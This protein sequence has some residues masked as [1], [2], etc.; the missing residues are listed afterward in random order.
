MPQESESR[1]LDKVIVRLPDGMRD[2]LKEAASANGRSMNAEIVARLENSFSIDAVEKDFFSKFTNIRFFMDVLPAGLAARIRAA[3]KARKRSPKEEV[4]Q[5]LEAAY[6]PPANQTLGEIIATLE[7]ITKSTDDENMQMLLHHFREVLRKNPGTENN[8]V[9]GFR[10]EGPLDVLPET[11]E[12]SE[13]G[14]R[15]ERSDL[16][17]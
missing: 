15:S 7:A 6:P 17:D 12:R 2:K 10:I 16:L 5:A 11:S 3:A 9:L 4:V 8:E 13:A 1:A 14:E